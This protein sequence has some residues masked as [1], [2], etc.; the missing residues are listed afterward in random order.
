[1]ILGRVRVMPSRTVVQQRNVRKGYTR[2]NR[3]HLQKLGDM[4]NHI[5]KEAVALLFRQLESAT[6]VYHLIELA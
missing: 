2:E 6:H 1:M 4:V 3:L 5:G